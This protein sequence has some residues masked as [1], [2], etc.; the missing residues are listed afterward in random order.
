MGHSKNIDLCCVL[1][2]VV[3]P[4][5]TSVYGNGTLAGIRDLKMIQQVLNTGIVKNVNVKTLLDIISGE[6]PGQGAE[7]FDPDSH[8]HAC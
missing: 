6:L 3:A 8:G 2:R 5:H 4:N 7:Q 1:E